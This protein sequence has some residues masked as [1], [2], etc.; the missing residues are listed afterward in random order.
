MSVGAAMLGGSVV[1]GLLGHDSAK[2]ASRGADR[3]T[4]RSLEEQGRQFDLTYEDQAPFRR[5][6]VSALSQLQDGIGNYNTNLPTFDGGEDFDF[7]LEADPGY[8]FARDEAIKAT[9]RASAGQGGYNSGNR[10]AAIAD[11]ITG[12]ASQYAND[13]YNR[14]IGTSRENYGRNLTQFNADRS[15]EGDLYGRDQNRLN[16]LSNVVDI[17]R[18]SV[19]ATGAAGQNF[20]NSTSNIRG[21]NAI[22]QGNLSIGNAQNLNNAIQGGASNYMLNNMLNKPRIKYLPPVTGR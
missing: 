21:S 2:D 22:N 16:R 6:G 9:N 5:A 12:V 15:R 18:G 17:G 13:A 20:A 11:R 7:N 10:L 4:R 1:S 3:A 14:Q 8:N 19:N